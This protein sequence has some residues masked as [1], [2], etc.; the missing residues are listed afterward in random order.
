MNYNMKLTPEEVE[1]LNGSKGE[2]MAKVV[3]TLVRRF[4]RRK[5]CAR[6]TRRSPCNKLRH[7][8]FKP[9]I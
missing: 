7:L 9:R 3:K 5:I 4:G 2:A 6:N 8:C 1:I